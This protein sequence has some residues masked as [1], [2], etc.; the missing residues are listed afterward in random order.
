[1]KPP[2]T[3][4][5]LDTA[6]SFYMYIDSGDYDK[7]WETAL[8]PDWISEGTDVTYFD[9]VEPGKGAFQ[10]WTKKEDFV[11]RLNEEIGKRGGK[12]RLSNLESRPVS[13]QESDLEDSAIYL[14]DFETVDKIEVR[15]K[16]LNTQL[17][18]IEEA[19]KEKA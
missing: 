3:E 11:E 15:V 18:K 14:A 13:F 17:D 5:P 4:T 12:I 2:G 16:S 10:G 6:V 8:E 7:A 1:M 9:E 19:V